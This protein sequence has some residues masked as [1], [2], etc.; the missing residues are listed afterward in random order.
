M[1]R[2]ARQR[3]GRFDGAASVGLRATGRSTPDRPVRSVP[4]ATVP[5]RVVA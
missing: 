4:S 5:E 1:E 3:Q 2:R